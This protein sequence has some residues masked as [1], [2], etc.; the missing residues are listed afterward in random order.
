MSED[1][2]LS[3]SCNTN[4]PDLTM[5]MVLMEDAST[6]TDR[7]SCGDDVVDEDYEGGDLERWSDGALTLRSKG[8]ENILEPIGPVLYLDLTGG[9]ARFGEKWR[10]G[11]IERL[12]D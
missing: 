3:I 1:S 4:S 6:L 9:S 5:W 10:I 12:S 2:D 11:E 8:V 7:S